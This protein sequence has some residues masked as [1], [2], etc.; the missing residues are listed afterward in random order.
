MN[1]ETR[2]LDHFEESEPP[3]VIEPELASI[4]SR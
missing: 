1:K 3:K 4:S 2:T